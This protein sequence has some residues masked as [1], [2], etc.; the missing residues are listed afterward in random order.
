MAQDID[1]MNVRAWRNHF[2]AAAPLLYPDERVVTFLARR[3]PDREANN[4]RK[5]LDIGFG[6]GR[7]LALLLEYGFE[8]Y[9]I[10][11]NTEVTEAC[12]K[13]FSGID[14]VR[15]LLVSSIEEAP[16][17]SNS[18][19]VIVAYG[20]MFLR[21]LDEMRRD[22]RL[23]N[24]LLKSGGEMIVNFRTKDN[25]FYGKGVRHSDETFHLDK[26]AGPYNGMWYTFLDENQARS[27]L[28]ETG[29]TVVN[30]E[31]LD[32]WRDNSTKRHSWNVFWAR[33]D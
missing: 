21:P 33:K 23:V 26:T 18:F 2:R 32:L 5:A 3:F 28:E 14:R 13:T 27:L 20:V 11:Y 4:R 15:E 31:R 1:Q 12:R 30:S 7:H 9:G 6:S 8:V 16:F 19:D 17:P 29:F 25:W 24:Q 10:D 22:F